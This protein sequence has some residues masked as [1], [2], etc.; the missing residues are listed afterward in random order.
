MPG[1]HLITARRERQRCCVRSELSRGAPPVAPNL[2]SGSR[3]RPGR[4]GGARGRLGDRA[5]LSGPGHDRQWLRSRTDASG[6]GR[7]DA[8]RPVHQQPSERADAALA[9]S[10]GHL[11]A[12]RDRGVP[13]RNRIQGKPS[14]TGSGSA[15]RG[16]SGTTRIPTAPSIPIAALRCGD[17][18]WRRRADPRWREGAPA[19][20]GLARAGDPLASLAIPAG[21][22]AS[23]RLG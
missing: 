8:D 7:A 10:S 22:G 23:K 14:S 3:R 6:P 12:G 16:R 4:A 5:R 11:S 9:R 15:M 2:E 17:L 20:R 21:A 1:L 13:A 19:R 18:P